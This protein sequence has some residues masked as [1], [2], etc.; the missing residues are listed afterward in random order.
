MIG[1]EWGMAGLLLIVAL[2]T[3]FALIGY[4]VARESRDPFGSLLALGLT[5]LIVVQA[6]LHIGVNLAL[7]PSTGVTLPFVSFGRSS[8]LVCLAAVGV[9]MSIARQTVKEAE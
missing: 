3:G 9:L 7:L 8:L 1:E 4:R 5:N 6:F 2:Y